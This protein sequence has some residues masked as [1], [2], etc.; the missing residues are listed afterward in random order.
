MRGLK[1]DPV[2][3]EKVHQI[4][5]A[6]GKAPSGGNSQQWEF[7]TITDPSIRKQLRDLVVQGLETYANANLRIPKQSVSE[8]LSPAN[9]VARMAQETDK[10]PVLILVCLNVKRAKRLTDEWAWL[11]EQSNWG[12]VFPAVQNM[13]LA[14]RALGLGTAVSIFPLFRID[15]L[16]TLL[17]LPSFIKPAILVYIG[18]PKARFSEPKRQPIETFIHENTW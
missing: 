15:E 16:R 17:K 10:V 12:S 14:A 3:P 5:E 8:F 6:A 18:Y 2:E 13:L 4:L 11:E 1:T 9:P 7:I